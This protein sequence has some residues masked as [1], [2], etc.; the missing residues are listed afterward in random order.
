VIAVRNQRRDEEYYLFNEG[1][2]RKNTSDSV[3]KLYKYI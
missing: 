2:K 3:R 1:T